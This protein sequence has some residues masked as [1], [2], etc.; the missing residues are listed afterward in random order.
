MKEDIK[1]GLSIA[2]FLAI[3]LYLGF[4]FMQWNFNPFYWGTDIRAKYIAI[5]FIFDIFIPIGV[6][7]RKFD[8]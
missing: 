2:F 8:D 6:A 4:S 7:L 1:L 5:N 3:F